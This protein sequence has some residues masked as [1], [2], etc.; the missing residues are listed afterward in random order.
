MR[1]FVMTMLLA[2]A[3]PAQAAEAPPAQQHD[4]ELPAQAGTPCVAVTDS[5][6][7]ATL[8]VPRAALEALVATGGEPG[9]EAQA[10]LA[11][12]AADAPAALAGCE[13]VRAGF[14]GGLALNTLLDG[15][16]TVL[17]HEGRPLARVTL[18]RRGADWSNY[19]VLHPVA[20]GH[21][22]L[23]QRVSIRGHDRQVR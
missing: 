16:G 15:G 10:V 11:G 1:S 2:G 19:D 4:Y 9:D 5:H 6:L 17:L 22:L 13:V 23:W 20:A 8:L 14:P 3:W 7:R 21:D 18:R 12:G